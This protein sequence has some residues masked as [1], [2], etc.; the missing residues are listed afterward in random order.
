MYIVL[1]LYLIVSF[2]FIEIYWFISSRK[3]YVS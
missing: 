2:L 1:D 3:D